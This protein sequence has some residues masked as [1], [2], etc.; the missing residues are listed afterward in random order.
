MPYRLIALFFLLPLALFAQKKDSTAT[1]SR[2]QV[3]IGGGMLQ[4]E[5]AFTPL[6]DVESLMGSNYAVCLRYFDDPLVG[7]QAE[8][9]YHQGGW[10]ETVD[11][12]FATRYERRIDFV[13]LLLLTQLSIGRGAVQPM[14]QAGPYLS[15]PLRNTEQIPAEYTDPGGSLPDVISLELPT[16]LNYGA[17]IGAGLNL[18][19]GP[20]TLQA[21]GRYLI[22]FSDLFKNG[23]S[24]AATSR[25]AGLGWH[26][27]VFYAIRE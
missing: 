21:E 23:T 2:L 14:L 15:V 5:V 7:F 12:L 26:I 17:Q 1:I 9:G 8:L 22:G 19:L 27:G 20:I 3:G 25:R 13:E 18:E 24:V 6:R 4:Q 10:A 16:R 11:T